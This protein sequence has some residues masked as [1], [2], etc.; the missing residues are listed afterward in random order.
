MHAISFR[1]MYTPFTNL[2]ACIYIFACRAERE[3]K[4]CALYVDF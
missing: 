1:L 3:K 2:F 4:T